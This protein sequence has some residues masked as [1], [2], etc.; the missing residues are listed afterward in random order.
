[1]TETAAAE[2]LAAELLMDADSRRGPAERARARRV[3]RLLSTEAG[4]GLILA[5]T[6]EV[7]RVREPRRAAA[8]LHDLVSNSGGDTALGPL[9]RLALRA[10]AGL[11]PSLPG[12]V[13]PAV[14]QR[15][16]S[17][18]AGVILPAGAGRL[19]RHIAHR[20]HQGIRLNI[21]VLGEAILGEDEAEL[22]LEQI[23]G[24]LAQ[25]AVDY[26]SVKISAIC[27]QLDVLGFDHEVERIAARLRRLYDAAN[28]YRPAKFVNLDMEEYR[29]L[30]L[31]LAV[32]RRVLDEPAYATTAAGIVLQAYLPDSLPAL[33]ELCAWARKRRD[34]TGAWVKVR[35]VK[36]ANLAMED[37]DAELHGW[38]A[39]P[40]ASKDETDANYKRMLDVVLDPHNDGAVRIGIATHNLFEVAW[41]A[42][43]AERRG[44]R[45]RVEF[46]MLEGMAP[47]VAEATAARLG[48]LLL[49]APIVRRG[50][51]E[52]A[53][54][55]LVRRLDEN[56]GPDNFLTHSFS[57]QVGSAVWEG[58]A[59]RFRR[60]VA[61]HHRLVVP[62]RR[63]QDRSA[64]PFRLAAGPAFANEPDTDFSIAPNREWIAQALRERPHPEY[65][66]VVA[67][68][69]VEGV[70]A[71]AGIDP[72]AP[73]SGA[74][75]RWLSASPEV[76]ASAVACARVAGPEWA[77][78]PPS[79]RRAVLEG[80]ADALSRRRGELLAVMACD[81]GK[82]VR[83]GDPEVSEAIDFATYYA[84]LI[85]A[86]ASGFR[87]FGTVV[88]APPW[89]FPLSIP[90]GGVL[91]ALAAGN[92]VILKPAPESVAVAA[93]LCEALWEGGVP[94]SV[95]QFAPCVDGDASK[96]L[97]THEHV[98]AVVLTGSWDT[99]RRFLEW[100]PD[101]S[102]H[103]ETS[104]KN[105]MV[106]TATADLDEAIADL[107]HSAFGHAGQKCSAASLAIV[108]ASVHDDPRFLR[109]LA[110]AV[111][112]LRVGPAGD[113][114]T[115]MG[116]LIRPPEGPLLEA[117]TRL[118]PGERWLVQPARLDAE[119][120]LWSPGVKVGVQPG[121]MFHLT[122][123]FGPVLGVMRAADLDEAIRWQN[124]PAYGLTAGL[125][126]LD[127]A[128]ID[129]W[130]DAVHAGNLYVNR[131]T[132]GA[133]VR[134]QPFGGWKRSVVGP[135]AKAGGPNYV[136]SLGTWPSV[137][138][139]VDVAG[140]GAGCRAAWE[141]MG[142]PQDPTGL[143]AEANAFRYR[144]LGSVLLAVGP[145]VSASEV[146]CA[147]A[148]AAAV[149]VQV[150]ET[151][152]PGLDKVRFLG[153]VDD[154]TRLAAHDA[155][156]WV[157]DIP[158]AADPRR[159]VLRWVREQAVSE[160]LH[161]HGNVTGRR[162]G[163]GR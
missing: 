9:D 82:T 50:D 13:L 124:Q 127:P 145:G 163:L 22:R 3:S 78:L 17:E 53:I 141:E 59:E 14:R 57:L 135:G 37:I 134:R 149:G 113:L 105:A 2:A 4:R 49:Y 143:A 58:E 119:G 31:T 18:M 153:P 39:A 94:R 103:A 23:L 142:V 70:P 101:L 47:A 79:G 77:S 100:R 51:I 131:G 11:A 157:D 21:N 90:A 26:V 25:P 155:G 120:Y 83:E 126:A 144:P 99:A 106:I 33:E 24:V 32:F 123:C 91:A 60:S 81:T 85:P 111:R 122:E 48:G 136:A 116:P 130:R 108:E 118:G 30:E 154:P 19:A 129:R 139:G 162:R 45:H 1:V 69:L 44:A 152:R 137:G 80:A 54:A 73:E 65:R 156:R 95:L 52:S 159:E 43:Q 88:V 68:R 121:S 87:P 56:S 151:P 28:A 34:R 42:T 16:R 104:G 46:E 12:L 125:H 84:S 117:F 6:D 66:P 27:S 29:D 97:I 76:V 110:D 115:T 61:A 148:A 92:A 5:L 98:D 71:E 15:V 158:V 35:L 75:Y 86:S 140:Y 89:N 72:S 63:V 102:L 93:V 7:L 41:A 36:G 161:R 62:T 109:R 38:P 67:G 40:F 146:A 147:R 107:V 20:H 138:A 132:T 8:V 96:L 128:E 114:V 10:G 64:A 112:S 160:R 150:V 74:A 55:Y 133:I